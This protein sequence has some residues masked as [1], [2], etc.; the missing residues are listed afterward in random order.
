MRSD[1]RVPAI[2]ITR[3]TKTFDGRLALNAVS[4][5]VQPGEMVALLGASGAGK[6]TLLRHIAGLAV[7]DADLG[8][9]EVLGRPMQSRGR[10][11]RQTTFIRSQ[12]AMIGQQAALI[13]GLSVLRNVQMG[14]LARSTPWRRLLGLFSHR[15]RTQ[16]MEALSRVGIAD[17]AGRRADSLSGD[18]RQR[19]AIARALVRRPQILL[20]DEPFAALDPVSSRRFMELLVRI[21]AEDHITVILSLHLA[22]LATR[23]CPRSIALKDGKVVYDGPSETITQQLLTE[24]YEP[25]EGQPDR[26]RMHM[27][28]MGREDQPNPDDASIFARPVS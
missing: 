1:Y 6:T 23:F 22:G 5:E 7:G 16:A 25:D 27:E 11:T 13:D 26:N 24:L 17:L 15:G 28:K 2:K 10:L 21:N 20:A 18:Q 14:S 19:T 4:L 8:S 12:I 3:L 9:I